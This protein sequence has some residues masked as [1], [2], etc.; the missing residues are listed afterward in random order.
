MSS[1]YAG[2]KDVVVRY[3]A[4]TASEAGI[5][6]HLI[7][8]ASSQLEAD[9]VALAERFDAGTPSFRSL[10]TATI[11]HSIIR[12]LRNPNGWRQFELDEGSFTR[13]SVLSSGLLK[14]EDHEIARLQP[15]VALGGIYTVPLG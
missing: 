10:V 13:D 1:P 7:E 5:V 9:V 3:R 15:R 2:P 6:P 12:V 11:A 14:F 8:D 4:L